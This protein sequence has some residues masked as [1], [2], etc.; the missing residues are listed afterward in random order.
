[1]KDWIEKQPIRLWM[2]FAVDFL[3]RWKS[4]AVAG[5][6]GGLFIYLFG[7]YSW[8]FWTLLSLMTVGFNFSHDEGWNE[9]WNSYAAYRSR[10][11]QTDYYQCSEQ[12]TVHTPSNI[13]DVFVNGFTVS[14][15]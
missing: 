10:I 7:G 14:D 4:N 13:S 3:G 5:L 11:P 15:R 12:S 9:G 6:M 8:E 2:W 1:M